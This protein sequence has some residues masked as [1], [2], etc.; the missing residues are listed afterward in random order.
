MIAV[1]TLA[2]HRTNDE[3]VLGGNISFIQR[4]TAKRLCT[5]ANCAL[6][7]DQ[8]FLCTTAGLSFLRSSNTVCHFGLNL[9]C[10]GNSWPPTRGYKVAWGQDGVNK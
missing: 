5:T 3:R 9:N 8:V 2:I 6:F 4:A 10:S 1:S 7:K